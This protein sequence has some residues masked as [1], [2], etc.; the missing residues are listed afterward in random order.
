MSVGHATFEPILD[1]ESTSFFPH[2][3]RDVIKKISFEIEELWKIIVT[4]KNL[5]VLL[6]SLSTV[7]RSPDFKTLMQF[8]NGFSCFP[9]NIPSRVLTYVD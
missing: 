3:W 1:A 7:T 9:L 5:L 6:S 4:G 2:A 8:V